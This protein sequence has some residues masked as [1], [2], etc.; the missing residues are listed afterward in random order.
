MSDRPWVN[1][2]PSVF[3][4]LNCDLATCYCE[5]FEAL[6]VNGTKPTGERNKLTSMQTQALHMG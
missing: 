5:Q 4:V 6:N 2:S 1:P 3:S